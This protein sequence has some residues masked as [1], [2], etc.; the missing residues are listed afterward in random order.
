MKTL[1]ITVFIGVLAYS[2][3]AQEHKHGTHDIVKSEAIDKNKKVMSPHKSAMAMVGEAH[4]HID[5]SSPRVRNRI[6]FGGLVGY[7]T[8]WQS[9]AHNVTWLETNKDLMLGE[10]LLP[11]GKYAFFTIPGKNVWKVMFNS[12]WDQHG[13][14]E[15]D[16]MKNIIT[17]EV[18]PE[19]L[20]NIQEELDYTISKTGEDIGE[21]S[22]AWERVLLKLPFQ[23]ED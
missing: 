21:I 10:K 9:G 11:A 20:E 3:F 13:K 15:Y 2:G 8:V 22:L 6:V 19:K 17:V 14:D 16:P 12:H 7:N 23:V 4:V 1:L 5:Y 18:K